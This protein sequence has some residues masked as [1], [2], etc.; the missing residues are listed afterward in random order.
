MN[1]ESSN[2]VPVQNPTLSVLGKFY[3]LFKEGKQQRKKSE[4]TVFKIGRFQTKE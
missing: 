2:L 3:F 4:V 1:I